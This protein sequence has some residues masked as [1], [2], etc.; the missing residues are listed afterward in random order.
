MHAFPGDGHRRATDGCR[1]GEFKIPGLTLAISGDDIGASRPIARA[2]SQ[3]AEPQVPIAA[4][5]LQLVRLDPATVGP[6]APTTLTSDFAL[7]AASLAHGVDALNSLFLQHALVPVGNTSAVQIVI[8]IAVH[9][10]DGG[11][12]NSAC[13]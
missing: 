4:F 9:L 1:L 5:T 7:E 3:S 12:Q 8:S 13:G 10:G 11:T 6:P 2:G